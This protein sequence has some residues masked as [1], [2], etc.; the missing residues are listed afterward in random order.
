[1]EDLAELQWVRVLV[2]LPTRGLRYKTPQA[3]IQ[4][5]QQ[6]TSDADNNTCNSGIGWLGVNGGDFVLHSL[7]WQTLQWQVRS[8]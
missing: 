8:M 5:H 7:E 2:D 6:R 1:M 4:T 3:A